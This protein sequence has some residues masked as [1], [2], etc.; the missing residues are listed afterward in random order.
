MRIIIDTGTWLKLDKLLKQKV[1]QKEFIQDLYN[2][3]DIIITHEIETELLH[4]SV[5][6]YIKERTIILPISKQKAY[7]RTIDDGFDAADASIFGII[8]SD[9]YFI[10][11]EN[12][13]LISYGKM[14]RMNFLFFAEF[15]S[16][17]LESDLIS[18]NELYFLNKTL[19]EL[20]NVPK[21]MF[22]RIRQIAEQY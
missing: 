16:K 17:L 2:L 10:L 22:Q 18:K 12:R 21:K 20:R 15:L 1:I 8:D 3:A 13:P 11:S 9:S 4:F 14:H 19:Y 7:Q 6:S 5:I